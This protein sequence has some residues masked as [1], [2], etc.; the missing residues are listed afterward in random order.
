MIEVEPLTCGRLAHQVAGSSR[1]GAC[2]S[3]LLTKRF[4]TTLRLLTS[5]HGLDLGSR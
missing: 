4:S 2:L 1:I 3:P 5:R